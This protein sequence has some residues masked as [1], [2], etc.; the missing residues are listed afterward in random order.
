MTAIL[1][2][3]RGNRSRAGRPMGGKRKRSGVTV[4]VWPSVKRPIALE[5]NQAQ[6]EESKEA[7]LCVEMDYSEKGTIANGKWKETFKRCSNTPAGG[8]SLGGGAQLCTYFFKE[9]SL[10][11]S[12]TSQTA[13]E[14]KRCEPSTARCNTCCIQVTVGHPSPSGAEQIRCGS[15]MSSKGGLWKRGAR[16]LR[17][18]VRQSGAMI[19]RRSITA[20]V[21]ALHSPRFNVMLG[22]TETGVD[23]AAAFA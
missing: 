22:R 5:N 2:E 3:K 9:A 21:C 6:T 16:P 1:Q 17:K 10:P 13:H 19:R 7:Q 20:R 12:Q 14:L 15:R 23:R 11:P 4:K 18:L 8:S